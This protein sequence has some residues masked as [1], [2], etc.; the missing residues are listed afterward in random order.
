[1]TPPLPATSPHW[2]RWKR[3]AT[4]R[5]LGLYLGVALLWLL[6]WDGMRV[7]DQPL[8]AVG[9]AGLI[10]GG[11]LL[12]STLMQ[13][14]ARRH[15][16]TLLRKRRLRR[17]LRASRA[18]YQLLFD[19]APL[20]MLVVDM[21]NSH[22]LAVND[23]AAERYGY[24]KVEFC[25]LTIFDLRP[26]AERERLQA[27]LASPA[28]AMLPR[29][30]RLGVW[31]HQ[32]RAGEVF[33]ADVS[34]CALSFAGHAARLVLARDVSDSLRSERQLQQMRDRLSELAQRLLGH[35]QALRRSIAR[36]LHD[37]IAHNLVLAGLR[38]DQ[39][40]EQDLEAKARALVEQGRNDVREG[41]EALRGLLKDLRPVLLD[42][43]GLAVAIADALEQGPG[44]KRSLEASDSARRTRWPPEVES[45]LFLIFREALSNALQHAR[46]RHIRVKLDGGPGECRLRIEDDGAG[47]PADAQRARPGHLGLVGMRER[48]LGIGAAFCIGPAACGGT[49]VEVH[50]HPAKLG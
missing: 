31:L 10:L 22:I 39:L 3:R 4:R 50:W 34:T 19:V 27:F 37:G 21:S 6:L 11:A 9:P 44:P 23:A 17:D 7:L 32:T 33:E 24:G 35:E 36:A 15:E 38:M 45:A 47:L 49:C 18:Q 42:Q 46:P 14:L 26:A 13:R 40:G 16:L 25:R 28:G 29:V 20:P 48:A 1:M 41:L 30:A 2:T 12:L 43:A 5:I 8:A